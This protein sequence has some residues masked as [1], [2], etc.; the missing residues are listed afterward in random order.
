MYKSPLEGLHFKWEQEDSCHFCI[1]GPLSSFVVGR[2]F[3]TCN[4]S[5]EVGLLKQWPFPFVVPQQISR[6]WEERCS[7]GPPFHCP[8]WASRAFHVSSLA[9]QQTRRGMVHVCRNKKAQFWQQSWLGKA[10]WIFL[11]LNIFIARYM[12]C[13]MYCRQQYSAIPIEMYR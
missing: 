6:L 12:L 9:E 13:Y 1:G 10:V 3:E 8:N 11:H 2:K 4:G 5:V 7:A